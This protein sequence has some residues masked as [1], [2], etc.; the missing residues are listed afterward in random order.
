MFRE[1]SLSEKRLSNLDEIESN[2]QQKEEEFLNEDQL[3]AVEILQK[4]SIQ[5]DHF[6]LPIVEGPPGTGKTTTGA[7]AVAKK[8]TRLAREGRK[9]RYLVLCF[10]HAACLQFKKMLEW[11]GV[12]EMDAVYLTPYSRDTDFK[13]GIFGV[14]HDLAGLP[15]GLQRWLGNSPIII[16]TILGISRAIASFWKKRVHL[17][18]DEYSQVSAADFF[19]CIYQAKDLRPYQ[20]SLLGDPLQL[21]VVTTQTHLRPNI[22]TFINPHGRGTVT[23][24]LKTQ[25]RM[26]KDICDA[27]NE[28][29]GIFHA[30][31]LRPADWVAD[32]TLIKLNYKWK[33]PKD[34]ILR[35]ILDPDNPLVLVDTSH[36][37]FEDSRGREVKFEQEAKLAVKI[38]IEAARSYQKNGE[39]LRPQILTPYASQR[40]SISSMLPKECGECTTIYKAQGAEYPM[41]IISFVR[42]NPSRFVGF[43]DDGQLTEQVYV[44]CS[45]A[46]AKLVVL[47]SFDTFF[48]GRHLMFQ[49]LERT[50]SA[51]KIQGGDLK[52]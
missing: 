51:V 43:L 13:Q 5:P 42:S 50:P 34:P 35:Q 38:A 17:M 36:L 46:Q 23:I 40:N 29:R 44:G 3:K 39:H 28:M 1:L 7:I 45:R 2:I 20:F 10:T 16:T 32:R 47:L 27:I 30:F 4:E 26:H 24:G 37:G 6:L 21:P 19:A 14:P 48:G 22:C 49:A 31:P 15:V 9:G 12:K 41:V 25:Y 52:P 11:I 33:P 8:L 18:I